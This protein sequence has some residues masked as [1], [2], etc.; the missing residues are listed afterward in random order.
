MDIR[1]ASFCSQVGDGVGQLKFEEF[2][3]CM[4]PTHDLMHDEV[5]PKLCVFQEPPEAEQVT[6]PADEWHRPS[7]SALIRSRTILMCRAGRGKSAAALTYA[8]GK[9]KK[10]EVLVCCP[11][12]SQCNKIERDW[13]VSAVT[14]HRMF[15]LGF[16]DCKRERAKAVNGV[17]KGKKCIVFDEVLLH[18]FV[19]LVR[20]YFFMRDHRRIAFLA[21]GDPKQL[22]AIGEDR[23][24]ASKVRD[25]TNPEMFTRVVTLHVNKR[26]KDDVERAAFEQAE[27]DLDGDDL[28]IKD[29]VNKHFK[30]HLISI[31]DMERLKIKRGVAL[32]NLTMDTLNRRIHTAVAQ[33]GKRRGVLLENGIKYYV[34]ESVVCKRQTWVAVEKGSQDDSETSDDDSA[35]DIEVEESS[36]PKMKEVLH[37]NDTFVIRK[38]T[39]DRCYI[40]D[41]FYKDELYSFRLDMLMTNFA[42]PYVNTVHSSQGDSIAEPF[43]IAEWQLPQVSK[44]WLYTAF[45]RTT[46]M[47]D[48]Y[49]LK[50]SFELENNSNAADAMVLRHKHEDRRA[51]RDWSEGEYITRNWILGA[52][53]KSATCPNCKHRMTFHKNCPHKVTVD[54]A[55]NSVAHVRSNCSLLCKACNCA[56]SNR[57]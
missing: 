10:E 22:E 50:G 13:E 42:L 57:V 35:D 18:N 16:D 51:Q 24:V 38:F 23:S 15:N 19:N 26:I 55:D 12:N 44:N 52:Y 41:L 43:V 2:G 29:W 53:A 54:R 31:E 33:H 56:K 37:T 4:P 40:S 3:N 14:L 34:G 20:I 47:G 32:T 30:G 28:S 27:A 1:S 45:S 8:L 9:F 11:Y 5:D 49:F 48:V 25:I 7:V 39:K 46:S 17:V 21:T 6:P 36:Q